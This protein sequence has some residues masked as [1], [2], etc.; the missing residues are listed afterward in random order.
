MNTAIPSHLAHRLLHQQP[1]EDGMADALAAVLGGAGRRPL[2]VYPVQD[3]FQCLIRIGNIAHPELLAD[4]ADD[5]A[6]LVGRDDGVFAEFVLVEHVAQGTQQVVI[7]GGCRYSAVGFAGAVAGAPTATAA[8]LYRCRLLL[9]AYIN[10]VLM[11]CH[12]ILQLHTKWPQMP[13]R[14]NGCIQKAIVVSDF[15]SN[16]FVYRGC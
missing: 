10:Q 8:G 3:G 9:E 1:T 2:G 7:A 12:E 11:R 15:I 6:Q 16:S 13:Q 4:L 5:V 14:L